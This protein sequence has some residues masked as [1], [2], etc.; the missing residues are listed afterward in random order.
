MPAQID[1]QL[2]DVTASVAGLRIERPRGPRKPRRPRHTDWRAALRMRPD[3]RC[4]GD[5]L[6]IL[7][8]LRL[9]PDLSGL[10]RYDEFA[11]R[12]EMTRAAPWRACIA[13]DT[14]RDDDDLALQAWLQSMSVDVRNR[15]SVADSVALIAREYTVHPVREYLDGLA[16]D[17]RPRLDGWLRDYLGCGGGPPAYLSAIGRRWLISAVARVMAPGCQADHT[18]VIEGPQGAG[19][20]SAA[21]VLAVRPDWYTDRLPELHTADAAIQLAGRWII[22]LSELAS[23]RSS[24][25]IESVKAYLTRTVD[26][27]RPPYGRRAV[28]IPRQCVFLGSTNESA[29]LRDRTGNRRFWPVRCGQIDIEA[30]TRDRDQLWAEALALY[31]AGEPWHLTQSESAL[32]ADEQSARVL[33]TELEDMVTTYLARQTADEV[34]TRDVLIYGLHL[35]PD[36]SDYVERAGRIGRQVAEAMERTGWHRVRTVGR[37]DTRRTIYRRGAP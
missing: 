14:W 31:R 22:E 9:A 10:V 6:A 27:C 7:T 21:R 13:G 5:E 8:A 18:L 30:L 12:V 4:V 3:G 20:S 1:D 23:L 29:Y 32:A 35:D 25:S 17:T 15:G 2:E 37:A 19:K 16:W 11:Q 26:V 28:S 24:A 34:S 36:A 33:S